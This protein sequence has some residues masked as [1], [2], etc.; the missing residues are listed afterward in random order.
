MFARHPVVR[1]VERVAPLVEKR[2]GGAA[3]I[4]RP[5]ITA[6][7]VYVGVFLLGRQKHGAGVGTNKRTEDG[8]RERRGG[9]GVCVHVCFIYF[10]RL[11]TAWACF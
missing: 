9:E 11:L 3:V 6:L 1:L 4:Y 5:A 2:V 7:T 10:D 8:K